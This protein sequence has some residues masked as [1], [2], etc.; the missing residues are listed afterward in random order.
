M[1]STSPGAM[2]G[3]S[4]LPN[5]RRGSTGFTLLEVLLALVIV[6][7]GVAIVA[8]GFYGGARAASQARSETTA[9]MLAE[10]KMG[11]LETG[12]TSLTRSDSGTFS[13]AEGYKYQIAV[14]PDSSRA[15]LYKVTVTVTFGEG[16]EER[17]VAL[18]RLM[19]ERPTPP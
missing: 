7:S 16:T 13:D 2:F 15:G 3:W 14:E 10:R 1:G 17:S 4:A 5:S 6:V 9:M 12:E 19:R 18:N 8:Q 11:D